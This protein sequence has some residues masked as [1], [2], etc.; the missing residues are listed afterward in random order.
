MQDD[1]SK[2]ENNDAGEPETQAE[3]RSKAYEDAKILKVSTP[4][5]EG[6]CRISRSYDRGTQEQWHVPCPHCH[7]LQ[8][9]EWEWMQ[10]NID[11]ALEAGKPASAGAT[12]VR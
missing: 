7:E 8:P 4:T 12:G 1:L 10:R 5:E 11:A 3:T 2:W 6:A 9:L